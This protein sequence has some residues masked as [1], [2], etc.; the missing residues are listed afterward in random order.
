MNQSRMDL[1]ITSR[2]ARSKF[3]YTN[4]RKSFPVV[5][6]LSSPDESLN[7]P[8]FIL[9]TLWP[10]VLY[11]YYPNQPEFEFFHENYVQIARRIRHESDVLV[12]FYA[13]SC[14]AH[15][16]MCINSDLIQHFGKPLLKAYENGSIEGTEILIENRF[17]SDVNGSNNEIIQRLGKAL[18]L[19]NLM[20]HG[21]NTVGL[22]VD[23]HDQ[24]ITV[25]VAAQTRLQETH[26]DAI[27]AF[28]LTLK[29]NV[30]GDLDQ[31]TTGVSKKLS[32]HQADVLKDFFDLCYWTLPPS[33]KIH[34][35]LLDLRTDFDTAIGGPVKLKSVML[36]HSDV[37]PTQWSKQ[38]SAISKKQELEN[39]EINSSSYSCGLWNLLHIISIGVNECSGHVMGDA[40]RGT[41][42][43]A[44]WVIRDFISLMI[45]DGRNND[46]T[47]F[48]KL[49]W[50][51]GCRDN[52][53][54]SFDSCQHEQICI[55][56]LFNMSNLQRSNGDSTSVAQWIWEVHAM[57]AINSV[58]IEKAKIPYGQLKQKYWPD[59]KVVRIAVLKRF[60]RDLPN[61]K[62]KVEKSGVTVPVTLMIILAIVAVLLFRHFKGKHNKRRK[63]Y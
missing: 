62:Q 8:S 47:R 53:I 59:E 13:I 41:P 7:I 31:L 25:S 60:R 32:R 44:A 38:C 48:H 45:P 26:S 51:K 19:D 20:Q 16:E 22:P 27:K 56:H 17:G 50:C 11:F 15:I 10:R 5:E 14:A 24:G 2:K 3:R 42:A 23:Q 34:Q 6:F 52:I 57:N 35:I 28:F 9:E 4:G 49:K 39:N 33:W 29:H 37:N 58:D 18:S 36:A 55:D 54:N 1:I 61:I 12:L 43:Y 46:D 30:F 21:H 63:R 40:I